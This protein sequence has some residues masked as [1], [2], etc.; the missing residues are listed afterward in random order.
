M[1]DRDAPGTGSTRGGELRSPI[2]ANS[3]NFFSG[4]D[5]GAT[6]ELTAAQRGIWLDQQII[7]D[8]TAYAVAELTR[9]EGGIDVDA[10]LRAV[11]GVLADTPTL[12]MRLHEGVSGESSPR[13]SNDA[14]PARAR[15]VD[16]RE[17]PDTEAAAERWVRRALSEPLD[18][19]TGVVSHACLLLT[20]HDSAQWFLRVH[21]IALD[22]YGFALVGRELAERYG[23]ERESASVRSLSRSRRRAREAAELYRRATAELLIYPRGRQAREDRAFWSTQEPDEPCSP[24]AVGG[25]PLRPMRR[26]IDVRPPFGRA[27]PVVLV[28]A[29]ALLAGAVNRR[30]EAVVGVHVM[31]RVG[32]D[33][34]SAPCHTQNLLPVRVR[35]APDQT[36]TGLLKEVGGAWERCRIHQLYRHEDVRADRALAGGE[37]L[38]D[39][40]LNIVP[41]GRIRHYGRALGRSEPV[42]DGPAEGLVLDVR[43]AR[44]TSALEL[45]AP[46]GSLGP[47]AL[48]AYARVLSTLLTTLEG[49]VADESS[50]ENRTG[51][52]RLRDL[53]LGDSPVRGNPGDSGAGGVIGDRTEAD[54]SDTV[55]EASTADAEPPFPADPIWAVGAVERARSRTCGRVRP[56]GSDPSHL[57]APDRVLT[58]DQTASEVHRLARLLRTRGVGAGDHV[59]LHLPRTSWALLAP[60]AVMEAGA[61]FVPC[62]TAWPARRL[63]QVR[64]DVAP[65]LVLTA[66]RNEDGSPLATRGIDEALGGDDPDAP[67]RVLLDSPGVRRELDGL[68]GRPLETGELTRPVRGDDVA[69]VLF[70]S[71]ST[72][73]PKGVIV[74]HRNLSSYAEAFERLYVPRELSAAGGGHV[75]DYSHGYSL[76]FDSAL[77]PA[78]AFLHGHRLH[79]PSQEELDD[80]RAHVRFLHERMVDVIDL[81]PAVLEQ[82]LEAGLELGG[83][84]DGR[85]LLTSVFIGGDTCSQRLWD[86]LR[87]HARHGLFAANGYGP[88]EDTVDASVAWIADYESPSIGRPLPGQD[89]RVLDHWGRE[90]PDGLTGELYLSGTSLA[91]GYL[92][93]DPLTRKRFI[94][95]PDGVRRYRTGDLVRREPD[96]SLTFVGRVGT[97]LSV[98]GVRVEAGEVETALLSLP[99]V[100]RSTAVVRDDGGGPRLVGYVVTDEPLGVEDTDRMLDS[101]RALLP[102]AFVPAALVGLT[103]LPL[104][105]RGKVDRAR[106]PAPERRVGAGRGWEDMSTTERRV[107]AVYAEVLGM[108]IRDIRSGTDLFAAGGHS[109]T[110]AR[111]QGRLAEAGH[112]V[113]LKDLLATTTVA[114]VAALLAGRERAGEADGAGSADNAASGP[115]PAPADG[116]TAA[117]ARSGFERRRATI[118][119]MTS[120]QRRLWVIEQ[121]RGPSPL[122]AIPLVIDIAGHLSVPALQEALVDTVLRHPALRTSYPADDHGD[123]RPRTWDETS[124]RETVR[125]RRTG[126]SPRDP[127][128][129]Q[130]LDMGLDLSRELPLRAYLA[131]DDQSQ[132]LVLVI[133]H[134]AADGWSLGPVL[135]TLSRAYRARFAGLD[136]RLAAGSAPEPE[137][138]PTDEDLDWWRRYL[139]DLPDEIDLPLDRSR[140]ARRDHAGQE[141]RTRL[142]R[143]LTGAVEDLARAHGASPFMVVHAALAALLTR[144]G[145]GTD[146]PVGTIG[147]G[148]TNASEEQTVGFFANTLVTRTDTSDNPRMEELVDRVRDSTLR[149]L[150]HAGTPFDAVVAAVNPPRSPRRHPLFQVMLVMQSTGS[151]R[152]DTGPGGPAASVRVAGTAT[153]K[154]DMTWELNGE[155]DNDE[156]DGVP[157]GDADGPG[158]SLR[159]EYA[160]DVLDRPSAEALVAWLRRLLGQ[161]VRD[162]RSRLWDEPLDDAAADLAR[163]SA[164]DMLDYAMSASAAMADEHPLSL[165]QALESS[166]SRHADRPALTGADGP[167]GRSTITYRDL[168]VR[169]ARVRDALR[170]AGAGPGH[171]VALLLERDVR[172]VEAVVG[173]LR[174][175]AAYVPLDPDYPVDR[176][177]RALIDCRPTVLLHDRDL[178]GDDHGPDPV[179]LEALGPDAVVLP[180][181]DVLTGSVDP[182]PGSACEAGPQDLAY[183]IFTS[184]STGRPKGVQVTNANVLRLLSSTRPWFGFGPDDVWTLFHSYA[185]DF[186]VW[187]M[188]GALLTGGR[189]VVVPHLVS[190]SPEEMIELL[191]GERVTVLNQTPSAFAQLVGAQAAGDRPPLAL[192]LVILGGE[193]MDPTVVRRWFE[194]H[195]PGR[196]TVINMYG[197]TET[198]V[199]VTYQVV[200]PDT[201]GISP[202]GRPIPDLSV[203]LLDQGG[204]PV[205]PGVVG[206]IHVGGAGVTAGYV[207]RPELTS[208]RFLP[209][210]FVHDA[211]GGRDG[212]GPATGIRI[213]PHRVPHLN[214]MYR[215]GDLAVLRRDGVLDFR[216]RRDRQVQ[217][218]GFRIELGEVEARA[219]DVDGVDV[220]HARLVS[221]NEGDERL[222]VYVVGPDPATADPVALRKRM[223]WML[224]AQM[225]P[226]AVVILDALPLTV[227]NKLD[228]AALP[229]PSLPRSRGRMP[230]TA[231]E[232]M[233][234]EQMAQVL[235]VEQCSVEDSFFD[236]GGHS[237]LAVTLVARLKRVTGRSLRV[238]TVMTSPTPALL[239]EQLDGDD[240]GGAVDSDLQVLLP[241]RP[242]QDRDA[243]AGG[244][245]CVHPAGGLSWCY[246]GLPRHLS[247]ETGV[248]G[249][250]ARGVLNP[251]SQPRSLAEMARDYTVQMRRARPD[252][253]YH[254]LGWSLG[255]M[256]AHVMAAGL[257]EQ[258]A[259]VGVLALLDAYPSEAESGVAEPP[260]ADALSAVLAMAGIE[261]DALAGRESDVGAM[262]EV[263]QERSSPMAGLPRTTLEALVRTY[264]NTARIL[265]EYRHEPYRG[266]VLFFR[267][268]RGGIGPEHDPAEWEPYVQG[269]LRVVDVDCTHREMTRPGPLRHIGTVL[270]QELR[271][272]R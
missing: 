207:G 186:S 178:H 230:R 77:S 43:G 27:D 67:E 250:Q 192:R 185:F 114:R 1:S 103:S 76:A 66:A 272:D 60:A 123:P 95:F 176:L 101:L 4:Y 189:L 121:D 128:L 47:G 209:D 34:L 179:L 167:S 163:R 9:L 211:M 24:L 206:E 104:T 257:Q 145:A 52:T 45:I 216:G 223:A 58:Y 22:G 19:T 18:L 25:D 158:M 191:A 59:L 115:S 180:M 205:P 200:G 197:I 241:L 120:A 261:D 81:S 157:P 85:R 222:V 258:G 117:R 237:M 105:D 224:P 30:D 210:P 100:R 26:G 106:L 33:L 226:A 268:S 154:F 54:A 166:L 116:T 147:S 239:A 199:H 236:L 269:R 50:E 136:P 270:D 254:L 156:S 195:P 238:G 122:Y 184:G 227:N 29:L 6:T 264:R 221:Q 143:S 190:R 113:R 13:M 240:R 99:G 10:W 169:S 61:A 12:R 208:E 63:E 259:R 146:V 187:E 82:L 267:A 175:G 28:S 245:F 16:L 89:A 151:P 14:V 171:R 165:A 135:E 161:M 72:G 31:G 255:G 7:D 68:S 188:F 148:R 80:P 15:L 174:C 55:D 129:I 229:L 214:R 49:A 232:R 118:T 108:E 110:A 71:G 144:C 32:R 198:T 69:Y 125:L 98:R 131:Q 193:A 177:A 234:C 202:V 17:E 159:L 212:G 137:P 217:L 78:V 138:E 196:P 107:A 83:V 23:C 231:T 42:W 92:E 134:I 139:H 88:T 5:A 153:S 251:E 271:R 256:V 172:Q 37:A 11:D 38:C 247:R 39:V 84:R 183:I 152:L 181:R 109:L 266:A 133:H 213:D 79:L 262:V 194:R 48:Q 252:G 3:E 249:L 94:T 65:V 102:T 155:E 124:V 173:T 127:R 130:E 242:S 150:E 218:R 20:G 201:P 126:A 112:Q 132:C 41:F 182:G 162:P 235:G 119:H 36:V 164:R 233:V 220:A 243:S 160:T 246:S 35:V 62:D 96:G 263:L 203:Y 44:E 57:D 265:R 168:D 2:E 219:L 93:D 21:H 64:R 46:R 70:T 91:R 111:I 253:P 53:P 141:V 244:V 8:P 142:G 51:S 149:V 74:E 260:V 86:T 40:A 73:R 87:D 228:A 225:A 75:L 56:H 248:W 204:H 170:R 215:S 97:N 140:P 90:L